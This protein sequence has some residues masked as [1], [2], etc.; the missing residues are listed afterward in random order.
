MSDMSL[1][2][3]HPRARWA[4][5]GAVLATIGAVALAGN[6]TASAGPSL[7]P[8]TAAQLLVDVQQARLS[9]ISGTV[10]QPS[11]LGLP[12]LPGL[13]GAGVGGGS[14]SLTSM[15]S[16][17]HTWRIW[18][19]GP[20]Q[21][22]VAL[23]GSLGES[24]V[25]RNGKDVWV[26]SSK[27]QTA[28][29]STLPTG[30]P[31]APTPSDLPSSPQAAADEALK[32]LDPTTSVTTSGEATVAG[33]AAYELVLRPKDVSTLVSQVRIAVDAAHHVPLRV[34]VY[35]VKSANPA[36]EV[37]FSQ[38]SF[39]T[40]DA[41]N[42][43]FNPPPGT[44]VTQS[45]APKTDAPKSGES[46]T[47]ESK[48]GGSKAGA[49]AAAAKA[50]RTVGTGWSTVVV[51]T[52]PPGTSAGTAARSSRQLAGILRSLPAVSGSWG[53]GR[54][55]QGTLFSVVIAD[56]GRVAVGAVPPERLYAALA[57]R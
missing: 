43:A 41:S 30:H 39:G 1:F 36:F 17:T 6:Q 57:A 12:E 24:D 31:E 4:V 21:A 35:S 45:T 26:W 51:A 3:D 15:I 22:R 46:K 2:V 37:S 8:R 47:G 28:P 14:S 16:G 53:S 5:P 34:Q 10:V 7:P 19:A 40:P 52:L 56:D 18:Y 48:T 9:G 29:H 13:S 11:N 54:V 44:K 33:Q 38:V 42:F 50:V 25:I 32:A 49:A 23:L 27:D 20:A 55:L